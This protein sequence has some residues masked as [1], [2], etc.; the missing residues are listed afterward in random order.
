MNGVIPDIEL[1]IS[2]ADHAGQG[3]L[4]FKILLHNWGTGELL[5]EEDLPTDGSEI[6]ITTPSFGPGRGK[7]TLRGPASQNHWRLRN[8][9]QFFSISMMQSQTIPLVLEDCPDIDGDAYE[10]PVVVQE[11][12]VIEGRE[13]AEAN[14][15]RATNDFSLGCRTITIEV[16]DRTNPAREY[17]ALPSLHG[18]DYLCQTKTLAAGITGAHVAQFSVRETSMTTYLRVWPTDAPNDGYVLVLLGIKQSRRAKITKTG[19]NTE[20]FWE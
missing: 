15:A 17:Q 12:E 8:Y 6:C 1:Q 10:P 20:I 5:A 11:G 13:D 2:L 3:L 9:E 4:G 16:E 19:A 18:R 14:E 7:L